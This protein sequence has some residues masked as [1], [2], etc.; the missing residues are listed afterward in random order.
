MDALGINL[1]NVFI[2]MVLFMLLYLILDKYLI[3]KLVEMLEKRQKDVQE[4]TEMKKKAEIRL[5]ETEVEAT[6]KLKKLEEDKSKEIDTLK[7]RRNLSKLLRTHKSKQTLLSKR[8][9]KKHR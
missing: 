7:T 2:Y 5:Q 1:V 4:G 3:S 8:L 9:I 6:E